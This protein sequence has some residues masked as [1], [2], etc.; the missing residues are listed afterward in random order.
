MP[1]QIGGIRLYSIKDLHEALGVNQRTLRAWFN[2][3]R[4]R[5]VKIGTRWH[6]TEE[7]LRKFL[8]GE[9]GEG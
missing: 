5:G 6:I 3:G 4:L 8:N 1:K 9:G 7:N 2:S